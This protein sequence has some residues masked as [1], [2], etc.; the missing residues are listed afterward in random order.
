MNYP[1]RQIKKTTPLKIALK[2]N[3]IPRINVTKEVNDL[4]SENYDTDKRN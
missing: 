2:K 4:Y 1:E 3:K